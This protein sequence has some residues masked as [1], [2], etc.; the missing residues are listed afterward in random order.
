MVEK[1]GGQ[2][3]VCRMMRQ[4][5][6]GEGGGSEVAL[7]DRPSSLTVSVMTKITMN[8]TRWTKAAMAFHTSSRRE[9]CIDVAGV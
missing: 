9:S 3:S 5:G 8:V 2:N 7:S 1:V 6:D 4:D